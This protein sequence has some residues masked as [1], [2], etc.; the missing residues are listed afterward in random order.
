MDLSDVINAVPELVK[1]LVSQVSDLSLRDWC[2]VSKPVRK[3]VMRQCVTR[4]AL[5]IDG[6][7]DQPPPLAA[8]VEHS[9]LQYVTLII[10][11]GGLHYQAQINSLLAVL[12]HAL[13]TTTVIKLDIKKLSECGVAAL[14]A[15]ACPRLHQLIIGKHVTRGLL[16]SF[17]ESC[18]E[19]CSLRAARQI[20]CDD[21][22]DM[23][24]LLPRL[25]RL[26]MA[27][28]QRLD[29]PIRHQM[30]SCPALSFI[31]IEN[32][33]SNSVWN[34]FPAG[35][36]E[37][38]CHAH[39]IT[40]AAQGR[41]PLHQLR[42]VTLTDNEVGGVFW[43]CSVMNVLGS[44]PELERLSMVAPGR[45]FTPLSL[46]WIIFSCTPAEVLL[47]HSI[48]QAVMQGLKI[49]GGLNIWLCGKPQQKKAFVA[50]LHSMP[51]A[52]G[53][54][55]EA[56][57]TG[58]AVA[59]SRVLQLCPALTSY[60]L[61]SYSPVRLRKL[62]PQLAL[63]NNLQQLALITQDGHYNTQQLARLI[64]SL[65]SLRTL[66]LHHTG[67]C[68]SRKV[69]T[70]MARLDR[71]TLLHMFPNLDIFVSSDRAMANRPVE[72][73][74]PYSDPEDREDPYDDD[75]EYDDDSD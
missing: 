30:L 6:L 39:D 22:H 37:L 53:V 1:W 2:L 7:S 4:C 70:T 57:N 24:L 44:A 75:E 63:C 5:V 49:D 14:L 36:V 12:V 31:S 64:P 67:F 35:L 15:A 59:C 13:S 16:A 58:D 29:N 18:P 60:A 45:A 68:L 25:S 73:D 69:R 51:M 46:P 61:K 20:L 34:A 26:E 19:L 27:E 41:K 43:A 74:E 9:Q 23:H 47:M 42:R 62:L 72:E 71:V 3:A 33:L 52:N 55:I 38:M 66:H 8:R 54:Y 40:P 17:G 32:R 11:H 10:K 28:L 56:V 48:N 50:A 21:V 65:T